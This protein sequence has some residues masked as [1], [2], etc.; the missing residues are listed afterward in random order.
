M[1]F[2]YYKRLSAAQK[3]VYDASERVQRIVLPDPGLL[4]PGIV[5]LAESLGEDERHRVQSSCQEISDQMLRSLQVPPVR[6]AVLAVRPSDSHGELHGL[7]DPTR[8]GA[9]PTISLWMRTAQRQQVVAF[10]TFFRTYLHEVC[11]HLDYHLLRLADSFHT[12]G[13]YKRESSLFHQLIEGR[14]PE[15]AER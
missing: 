4:R 5:T 6:I 8:R 11:H 10:R 7:Y 13:F 3:R 9:A 15:T 2:G 14:P 1:P 12:Q